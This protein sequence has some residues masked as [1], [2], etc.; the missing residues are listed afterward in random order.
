M[1]STD[2]PTMPL[3]T[4]SMFANATVHGSYTFPQGWVFT[5]PG[6][7]RL[8]RQKEAERRIL[9]GCAVLGFPFSPSLEQYRADLAT[10]D[11]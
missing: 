2:Q 11:A 5:L 7:T 4:L 6:D 10:W 9:K 1:S 3:S 8:E